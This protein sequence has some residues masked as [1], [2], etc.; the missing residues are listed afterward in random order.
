MLLAFYDLCAVLTPCGPLKWLIKVVQS[1]PDQRPLPGLLYEADVPRRGR[2]GV[3]WGESCIFRSFR[4]SIFLASGF[5]LHFYVFLDVNELLVCQGSEVSSTPTPDGAQSPS[6]K[7]AQAGARHADGTAKPGAGSLTSNQSS[8]VPAGTEGVPPPRSCLSEAEQA[9]FRSKLS[10]YYQEHNPSK[11][12]EV[13]SI[14][15]KFAGQEWKLFPALDDT[16]KTH[17]ASEE[18][19]TRYDAEKVRG[20]QSQPVQRLQQ[21][22]EED[23]SIKLGLGDFVFYSVSVS[24]VVGGGSGHLKLLLF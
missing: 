19:R 17:E 3:S 6:P 4:F 23:R 15:G 13:E 20:A 9:E 11:V 16:Y 2:A 5:C 24:I 12:G 14:L 10:N 21:E 18:D 8:N 7:K 22:E 1:D